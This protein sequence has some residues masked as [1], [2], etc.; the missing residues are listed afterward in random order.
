MS[1]PITKYS[2]EELEALAARFKEKGLVAFLEITYVP[3][4]STDS[5]HRTATLN[6]VVYDALLFS[7]EMMRKQ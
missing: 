7:A 5:A 4:S 1:R 3:D 2:P 6:D